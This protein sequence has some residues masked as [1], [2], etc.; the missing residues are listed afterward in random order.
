MPARVAHPSSQQMSRLCTWWPR[1][2][3][4]RMASWNPYTREGDQQHPLLPT[5]VAVAVAVVMGVP[6]RPPMQAVVVGVGTGLWLAPVGEVGAVEVPLTAP[7]PHLMLPP[8][9]Y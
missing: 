6:L 3:H 2:S 5:A 7:L 1:A 9:A 4:G 8:H